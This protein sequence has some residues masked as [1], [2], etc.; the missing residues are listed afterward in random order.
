MYKWMIIEFCLA[1]TRRGIG[2]TEVTGEL[3][4]TPSGS[5]PPSE[6]NYEHLYLGGLTKCPPVCTIPLQITWN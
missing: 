1:G 4:R 6:Y 5:F 2:D 3:E